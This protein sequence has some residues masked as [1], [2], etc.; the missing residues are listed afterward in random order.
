[1]CEL[2]IVA[3]DPQYWKPGWELGDL[4][5]RKFGEICDHIKEG[6]HIVTFAK[7]FKYD[8]V[9]VKMPNNRMLVIK[10][11]NNTKNVGI[12]V[13]AK[14]NKGRGWNRDWNRYHSRR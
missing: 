6:M 8:R 7:C 9:L 10:D 2:I 4:E 5:G 1:M 12:R 11:R 13:K 14:K 3:D